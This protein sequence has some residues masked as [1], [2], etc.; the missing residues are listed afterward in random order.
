MKEKSFSSADFCCAVCNVLRFEI[1][2]GYIPEAIPPSLSSSVKFIV[3]H[4]TEVLF[5]DK[6]LTTYDEAIKTESNI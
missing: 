5:S 1:Q 2:T 3:P 4:F 6:G